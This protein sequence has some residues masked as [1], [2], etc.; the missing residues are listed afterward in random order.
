MVSGGRAWPAA[1]GVGECACKRALVAAEREWDGRG[2]L[3]A[4]N[5]VGASGCTGIAKQM[6]AQPTVLY[7]MG[8]DIFGRGTH[9]CL[10]ALFPCGR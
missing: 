5:L 3:N 1:G 2:L 8:Q 10:Q 7:S 6:Q 9:G 4:P